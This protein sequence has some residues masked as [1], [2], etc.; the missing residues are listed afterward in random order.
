MCWGDTREECFEQV[1]RHLM[2]SGKHQLPKA[3][4]LERARLATI[5]EAIYE[6][7]EAKRARSSYEED[8]LGEQKQLAVQLQQAQQRL[9]QQLDVLHSEVQQQ[10]LQQQQQQ[11]Q[12]QHQQPEPA[13][14]SSWSSSSASTVVP[15]S[16]TGY[17]H[18]RVHEFQAA[19]DCVGRALH[20]AKAAQHIAAT[21]SRAFKEEVDT[22]TEVKASLETIKFGMQ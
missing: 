12:R 5:E 21:A 7:P 2:T 1:V 22:L 14:K 8:S 6:E 20:S 4:A 3:E 19:I 13:T 11:Q 18:L 15:A 17:A 9:A 10:Q 16:S